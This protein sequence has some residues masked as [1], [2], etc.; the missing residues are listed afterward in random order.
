M[1]NTSTLPEYF[2]VVEMAQQG[3]IARILR[4]HTMRH[5]ADEDLDLLQEV[6]PDAR[7]EVVSCYG[8]D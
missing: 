3:A 6:T 7:Y 5:R 2:V 1:K 4:V 8:T